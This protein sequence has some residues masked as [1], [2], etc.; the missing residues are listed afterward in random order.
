MGFKRSL[1]CERALKERE[2]LGS[3]FFFL[4]NVFLISIRP[5]ELY[6]ESLSSSSVTFFFFGCYLWNHPFSTLPKMMLQAFKMDDIRY[7]LM[8]FNFPR[9]PL[10]G[11][12]VSHRFLPIVFV[13]EVRETRSV[14]LFCCGSL[15]CPMRRASRTLKR[16][17]LFLA[18][19]AA[20][21]VPSMELLSIY[22]KGGFTFP[23]TS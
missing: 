18:V 20:H 21:S 8:L 2:R 7:C 4:G 11:L 13:S 15:S 5:V 23:Y 19:S 3:V 6:I 9:E 12:G 22:I 16:V 14:P 1:V 17:N 10:F